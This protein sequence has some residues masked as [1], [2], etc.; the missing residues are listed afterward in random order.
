ML[1]QIHP[2]ESLTHVGVP[3]SGL[4]G[5]KALSKEREC[6]PRTGISHDN[7][8]ARYIAD[9]LTIAVCRATFEKQAVGTTL[10]AIFL[11][12]ELY[13]LAAS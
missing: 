9:R 7:N 4:L 3:C 5:E 10:S 12:H 8:R 2:R 1:F 6:M 11:H 13:L